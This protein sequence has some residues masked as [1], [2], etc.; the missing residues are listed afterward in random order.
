MTSNRPRAVVA[1]FPFFSHCT[2]AEV[3]ELR[4]IERRLDQGK[5]ITPRDRARR[6]YLREDRWSPHLTKARKRRAEC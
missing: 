5:T 1:T 6:A 3:D 4:E 2:L